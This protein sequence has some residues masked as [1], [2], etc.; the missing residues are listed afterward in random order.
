M[1]EFKD[2]ESN[3]YKLDL[4]FGNVVRVKTASDGKFNLLEPEAIFRDEKPLCLALW[5]DPLEFYELLWHLV[6]P[7]ATA[8][9]IDAAKFGEL[10]AADCIHTATL[11]FYESWREFF[12]SLQRP[13]L[14]IVLDKLIAYQA[15]ALEQMNKLA[16]RFKVADSK[17]DAAMEAELN[18]AFGKLEA[19]LDSILAPSPSGS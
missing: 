13:K 2:K 10:M 3:T 18:R 11:K 9:G 17:M 14:A 4:T 5:E 16:D 6:E 8:K 19:S 15:K 1:R 7:Q 12:Q